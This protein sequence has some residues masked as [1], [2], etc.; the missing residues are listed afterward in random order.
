[1]KAKAGSSDDPGWS[2][3]VPFSSPP[4]AQTVCA[5]GVGG[6][7]MPWEREEEEPGL[8]R[9]R[10]KKAKV[11]GLYDPSK[12]PSDWN[13]N[14]LVGY[15]REQFKR[16]FPGEG[17]PDVMISDLGAAKRRI[18][19]MRNEEMDVALAKKAVDHLFS[20]W[21]N[22]LPAR[23]RWKDSRPSMALIEHSRLFERIVREV[24][25]GPG[26]GAPGDSFTASDEEVERYKRRDEICK[27]LMDEGKP[28]A[29]A[30]RE[31]NRLAGIEGP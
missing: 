25:S 26:G 24:Q 5:D 22:G 13:G 29:E 3:S 20:N 11:R 23:L 30:N 16:T 9:R 18:V 27:R 2:D 8:R 28:L 4:K 19:W 17:A 6:K 31:A 21:G 10:G 7:V 14:D 1:V 15:F 12:D